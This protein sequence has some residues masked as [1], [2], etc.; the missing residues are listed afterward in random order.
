MPAKGRRALTP[1]E[2]AARRRNAQKSTGPR[3]PAGKR[4][5]ALNALKEGTTAQ[6]PEAGWLFSLQ[7]GKKFRGLHCDL[8]ALLDP[9][10]NHQLAF[11]VWDLAL[12]FLAK[13]VCRDVDLQLGQQGD[14]GGLD[15]LLEWQLQ[16]LV[17][18]LE[19]R[20]RKW[21]SR[22]TAALGEPVASWSELRTLLESR[23]ALFVEL[24]DQKCK[25]AKWRE[26]AKNKGSLFSKTLASQLI[27][28]KRG[29]DSLS[30]KRT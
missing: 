17:D 30:G 6:R 13:A 2:I 19:K 4:R 8:I 29:S 20:S 12:A 22:L 7:A 11:E 21:Y 18:T 3:T 26:K 25:L 23:L 1:W 10:G 27:D 28:S 5:S 15:W 14:M 24:D 16:S 9:A